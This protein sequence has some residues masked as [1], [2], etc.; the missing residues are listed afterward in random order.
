MENDR[1]PSQKKIGKDRATPNKK[2]E[3]NRELPK[4]LYAEVCTFEDI[5]STTLSTKKNYKVAISFGLNASPMRRM[6]CVFA[7]GAQP[8]LLQEEPIRLDFQ[9]PLRPCNSPK[10]RSA[11]IQKVEVAG[12]I[13]LHVRI[14]ESSIRAMLEILRNSAGPILLGTPLV[15]KIIKGM[16]PSE[17][18]IVPFS[19]P[20][21]KF[22]WCKK[23]K[24]TRLESSETTPSPTKWLRNILP[25]IW[26]QLHVP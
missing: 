11:T 21:R 22:L 19:S 2:Q 17:R 25:K 24:P 8:N 4:K 5:D 6:N 16:F 12:T 10:L 14:G 7:N 20:P 15:D 23:R 13:V 18:M 26:Y 3:D 9:Q 1:N